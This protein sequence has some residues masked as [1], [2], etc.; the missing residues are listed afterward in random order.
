M[1]SL[2]SIITPAYNCEKYLSE[3]IDSVIT[4]SYKN[5]EM[6]IVD[7]NSTDRT[8]DIANEY[9]KRDNRIKVVHL[10]LN[11]GVAN[12]RNV[13][14]ENSNGKYIAFL[15]SDDNW[16]EHKLETQIK[17]MEKNNYYFSFT[18]YEL[19]DE[20]GNK[21][22]K[23]MYVPEKIDFKELLKG[24][25]IP[26]LTV[27]LNKEVISEIY[28]PEIKHEDYATWLNILKA[29]IVAYGLDINLASYR[30]SN[31]SLSGNKIK[32]AKWTWD[33]YTK[34]LNIKWTKALF[35]M[36]FYIYRAIKKR[37]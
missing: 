17:F 28:M 32:S 1:D 29:G 27:V 9:A 3:S 21:L 4:Q 26:C 12:A 25:S 31:A 37:S 8:L 35:Y 34:Y 30:I 13:A 11:R 20:Y 15:D 16:K 23:V 10:D 6:I 33:I 2:V 18:S 19:V 14:I 36:M 7:D 24:N 22:N 5:W